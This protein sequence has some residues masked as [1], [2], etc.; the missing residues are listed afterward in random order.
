MN[1]GIKEIL[2]CIEKHEIISFDIFNTLLIGPFWECKDM[3]YLLDKDFEKTNKYNISFHKIRLDAEIACKESRKLKE[4]RCKEVT[5][6]EIYEYIQ[7]T[8]GLSELT[9]KELMVK[10]IDCVKNYNYVRKSGKLLFDTA[11]RQRKKIVITAE[12]YL[13]RNTIKELLD[14][15]GY[16]NLN[17]IFLSSELGVFKSNGELYKLLLTEL[18]VESNKVLHIGSDWEVDIIQA[19]KIGFSTCF[20]PKTIDVFINAD[21]KYQTNLCGHIAE[22]ICSPL[23]C[24]ENIKKSIG[25]KCMLAIVAN[26]YFDDPF[27]PFDN[28]TDFNRD[29]YFIGYYVVGMHLAGVIQWIANI[30][31]DDY[32]KIWFTSRDGWLVMNAYN[33]YQSMHAELPSSEYLYISRKAMMCMIISEKCDFF[34]LPINIFKFSPE[35]IISLLKFCME[36]EKLSILI[37]KLN[38]VGIKYDHKFESISEYHIFINL[39]LNICYSKQKHANKKKI[40][41]RYLENIEIDDIIFDMGYS[42]RIHKSICDAIG[43]TPAALFIHSDDTNHYRMKHLGEFKIY[44]FYDFVPTI[45]FA[46][47]EFMLSQGSAGCVGYGDDGLPIF[48]NDE[49][50][51][52]QKLITE[53]I[54]QGALDFLKDFY[55]MFIEVWDVISFKSQE[56]SMP[57]EGFMRY[58]CPQDRELFNTVIFED[59]VWGAEKKYN[60]KVLT[61]EEVKWLPKYDS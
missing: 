35:K 57:F 13:D 8:Y 60:L 14:M 23:M 26:K 61:E 58:I 41:E 5:L 31:R 59:E 39:F 33:L 6:N 45:S 4:E 36:E 2:Q 29:P 42:G 17:N 1:S 3:Y 55:E 56:V 50:P 18:K 20:L 27:R 49:I 37:D 15:N 48:E 43:K 9:C 51:E 7:K 34:D 40:V 46:F 38:N 11:V 24:Y 47:R 30:V 28:Q 52:K 10:E 54:Q 12:T 32:R 21:K 22:K 25:Y 16:L 44:E 53:L 19:Q